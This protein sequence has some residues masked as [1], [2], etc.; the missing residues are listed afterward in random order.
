[1]FIFD[2]FH[3]VII[4]IFV[5]G[6]CIGLVLERLDMIFT[7]E[8]DLGLDP[9]FQKVLQDLMFPEGVEQTIYIAIVIG[10]VQFAYA[11]IQ[12]CCLCCKQGKGWLKC[13][14]CLYPLMSIARLGLVYTVIKDFLVPF[15]S[16]N[17]CSVER[18]SIFKD[19]MDPCYTSI[20]IPSLQ[21]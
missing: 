19:A 11:K 1:M 14:V 4:A 9:T 13:F 15:N 12:I 5:I 7:D 17:F 18:N 8:M 10:L 16:D 20:T 3:S 2:L 6:I 21:E